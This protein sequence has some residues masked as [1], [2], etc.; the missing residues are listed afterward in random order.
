MSCPSLALS[1]NGAWSGEEL[2]FLFVLPHGYR[3]DERR[4]RSP[5]HFLF[6]FLFL[7]TYHLLFFSFG[8]FLVLLLMYPQFLLITFILPH[9]Y[10]YSNT[11]PKAMKT[12]IFFN[13]KHR[14]QFCFLL[15]LCPLSCC[16]VLPAAQSV[17]EWISNAF[18]TLLNWRKWVSLLSTSLHWTCHCFEVVFV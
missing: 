14:K 12:L 6:L 13:L 2:K 8:T 16:F 1:N 5:F 17:E 4:K 11:P 3:L 9:H 15:F 18:K 10:G 7:L